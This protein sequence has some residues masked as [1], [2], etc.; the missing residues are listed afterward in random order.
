MITVGS[1]VIDE[2]AMSHA[3]ELEPSVKAPDGFNTCFPL[4]AKL[5]L[6]NLIMETGGGATNAA[7]T[8]GRLGFRTA[9]VCRVGTDLMGE[10]L[11]RRLA[12]DGVDTHLVQRDPRERTGQSII[13]V[14][15][16][17]YRSILV[18]RGASGN[19]SH[20]EVPW[21]KLRPRWFY[22]TA[23]GGNLG[24]LSLI[25]ERAEQVGA[26]VAW[27]PG[28]TELE[29]GLA[30]LS[31][32]IRRVDVLD[33]NREEAALLAHKPT[34]HL[35]SIVNALGDIPKI[36]LLLT[37]GKRGAYLHA[38]GCTWHCPALP[39]KRV[40]TTGAGD[41]LGSGFVAGFMKTCDLAVGLKVGM[42]NALGVITHMGAKVGILKRWPTEREL[43]HVSVKTV[44]LRD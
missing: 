19:V 38:R 27:N 24:L 14:S 40:N 34:R 12:E 6:T 23:L 3:F 11:T 18:F 43:S 30:R 2:Y 22:V 44:T 25:L 7:V 35:R 32:L 8:F 37:D 42:L 41:A 36:G 28:G 9:T 15:D 4:G 39:G 29:K 16:I 21:T 33:V 26:R 5:G 10:L 13:L 31:P 1:A 17:G 20:R